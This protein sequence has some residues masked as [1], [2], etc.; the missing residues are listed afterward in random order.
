MCHKVT[1]VTELLCSLSWTQERRAIRRGSWKRSVNLSVLM[2]KVSLNTLPTIS[3]W[4]FLHYASC[5]AGLG[6]GK[7]ILMLL[8]SWCGGVP[9]Q[10]CI[11]LGLM[12]S[13]WAGD[14]CSQ[15]KAKKVPWHLFKIGSNNFIKMTDYDNVHF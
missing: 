10:E 1:E 8:Y 7:G 13:S 9:G 3:L 15:R 11:S 14:A 5:I 4:P 12:Q 2:A 6:E